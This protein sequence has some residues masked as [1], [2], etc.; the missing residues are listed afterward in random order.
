[1]KELEIDRSVVIGPSLH[2]SPII[3]NLNNKDE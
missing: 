2:V 1:V 3:K